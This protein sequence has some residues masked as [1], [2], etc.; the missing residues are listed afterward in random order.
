[1]DE[2]DS[3]GLPNFVDVGGGRVEYGSSLVIVLGCFL[4]VKRIRVL[5][6]AEFALLISILVCDVRILLSSSCHKCVAAS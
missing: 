5:T 1:M 3:S 2:F 6:D 4:I